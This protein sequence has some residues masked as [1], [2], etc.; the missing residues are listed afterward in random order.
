MK[1][2]RKFDGKSFK[3]KGGKHRLKSKAKASAKAS[4]DRGAKARIVKSKKGYRVF[5][6]GGR[7]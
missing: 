1:T 7:R 5:T 3:Q 2:T 6:R 4:R